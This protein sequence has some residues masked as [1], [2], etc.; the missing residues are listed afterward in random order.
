[1]LQNIFKKTANGDL[2]GVS[3]SQVGRAVPC[4]PPLGIVTFG[5]TTTARTE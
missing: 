4:P 5:L 2:P 1:M 3:M